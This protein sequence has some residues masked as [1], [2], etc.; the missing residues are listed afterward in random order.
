M[1]KYEGGTRTPQKY[2]EQNINKYTLGRHLKNKLHLTQ[3]HFGHIKVGD[4]G[5]EHP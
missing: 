1:P 4:T 5:R 3:N 2:N